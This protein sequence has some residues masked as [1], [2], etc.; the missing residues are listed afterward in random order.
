MLPDNRGDT[1][2]SNNGEGHPENNSSNAPL[3][4]LIDLPF[5][6]MPQIIDKYETRFWGVEQSEL[7]KQIGMVIPKL[8]LYHPYHPYPTGDDILQVPLAIILSNTDLVPDPLLKLITERKFGAPPTPYFLAQTLPYESETEI[9]CRYQYCLFPD[10][11]SEM[12]GHQSVWAQSVI[13]DHEKELLH[14]HPTAIKIYESEKNKVSPTIL[15]GNSMKFDKVVNLRGKGIWSLV[16][17]SDSDAVDDAGFLTQ[18]LKAFIGFTYF[19]PNDEA[20]NELL[21]L[22]RNKSPADLLS[23]VPTF[24]HEINANSNRIPGE[25]ELI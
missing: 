21:S 12:S 22:V 3:P 7:H 16:L 23:R 11:K 25:D 14:S 4:N 15:C 17:G 8:P 13:Y 20:Y 10:A 5:A 2:K 24:L 19:I 9:I 6:L 1:S 18:T